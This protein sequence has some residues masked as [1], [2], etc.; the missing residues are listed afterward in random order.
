M[1][2]A[3]GEVWLLV[4]PGQESSGS[5]LQERPG[6]SHRSGLNDS[7]HEVKRIG[8][9]PPNHP[10]LRKA[11]GS[12]WVWTLRLEVIVHP[13]TCLFRYNDFQHDNLSR[14]DGCKPAANGENAISARSDLNPAN[15]TYPFGALTQ[16]Q[17]G[18]TDMKVFLAVLHSSVP[19][20][21]VLVFPAE[22]MV[23]PPD[24]LRLCVFP[25]QLTSYGMFRNYTMIAVSGPTWDQVPPFNWSTSPYDKLLHM[26]HPDSWTFKPVEVTWRP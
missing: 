22:T 4:H 13:C 25:A 9:R 6:K 10:K 7:P 14:C 11:G 26:G 19:G 24:A 2:W 8:T 1:Q 3:G 5:D 12:I 15:G 17:H 20:D 21:L 23:A 18:G 16:R